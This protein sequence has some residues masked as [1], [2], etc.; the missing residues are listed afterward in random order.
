MSPPK[1]S[2][3]L[4]DSLVER[5][6]AKTKSHSVTTPKARRPLTDRRN[7]PGKAQRAEFTPLLKSVAKT[8]LMKQKIDDNGVPPTPAVLKAG[9]QSGN[10]S[11]SLP[12][13]ITNI[14]GGDTG[15]MLEVEDVNGTTMP[16]VVSSSA[17][18]TPLATLPKSD[19]GIVVADGEKVMTL[20]EQENV[21]ENILG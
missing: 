1:E 15:S 10:P 17:M 18:S 20:R 5:Y 9:Y 11:P 21:S 14:N 16:L 7:T 2:P 3:N 12:L 8:N 4:V 19:R 13:D 6:Q